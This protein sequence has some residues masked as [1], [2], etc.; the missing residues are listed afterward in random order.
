MKNALS[1]VMF[2]GIV[3]GLYSCNSS[4]NSAK[5]QE[6]TTQNQTVSTPQAKSYVIKRTGEKFGQ[7]NVDGN[8]IKFE[9]AGTQY[10][11]ELK[12]DKRKY[13]ISGGS[14]LT[15]VKYKDDGFKVRTEDG[16]LLWKIKFYDDKIKISNNEENL[17]AY[18]IKI[19]DLEKIKLKKDDKEIGDVKL[20]KADNLIE[21]TSGTQSYAIEDK[22]L[23]LA[24][25]VLLIDAI[26][27]NL[28]F[29]IMGE[30]LA[31]GK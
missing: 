23:S 24:Y 10:V 28:K 16:K 21:V 8:A 30:L 7:I 13:A 19:S 12:T 14:F 29:V 25:G 18:E 27:D 1:L 6:Q 26:P 17:N 5:E 2:C 3:F 15:E 22:N 20:K 31:K 9:Y 11:S 4:N